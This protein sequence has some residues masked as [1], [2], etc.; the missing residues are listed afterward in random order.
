MNVDPRSG[1]AYETL[2]AARAEALLVLLHGVGGNEA[3]LRGL[4]R[5]QDP[6]LRCVLARA[7]LTFG[8]QSHGWFEVVFGPQ[9]PAINSEQAEA[10]RQQ[11]ATLLE[12]LQQ[13]LGIAPQRTLIAGFSQGGIMSAGLGLTRPELVA[14]FGLLSGRILPE[15]APHL[16]CPEDL[17]R[18]SGFVSHGLQDTKLP[19]S[20][21]VKADAWLGEL[22]VSFE[23]HRYEAGHELT[24]AMVEDFGTW[25]DRTLWA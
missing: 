8:P 25:V 6:R 24:P 22:G 21:A 23:T 14:G 5:Q 11:L 2:G 9:G 17:R 12:S 4:A 3:Q 16:A 1:L 15:L 18:L 13:E 19:V 10:N 7:P 20:W